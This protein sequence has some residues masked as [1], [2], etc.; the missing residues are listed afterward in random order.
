M[1]FA[2]ISKGL[3]I[4]DESKAQLER[5]VRLAVGRFGTRINRVTVRL[6]DVNGPRGGTDKLCRVE[7]RIA[8]H[9]PLVVEEAGDGAFAVAVRAIERMSRAVDRAL[10]RRFAARRAV[11]A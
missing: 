6:S 8:G 7:T 2:V 4:G 9:P 11:T 10:A 5:R 1:K 3:Q